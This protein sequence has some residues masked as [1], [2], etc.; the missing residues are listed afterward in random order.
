MQQKASRTGTLEVNGTQLY[1][2][3]WGAG[4][5][6]VLVHAGIADGRMWDEQMPVF[7]QHYRVIRFDQRGF[8]RSAPASGAFARHEDLRA[9]LAALEIER[10]HL[11]GCSMG[12]K[13]LIDVV[14]SYPAG[15]ASLT[16]VCTG[17]YAFQYDAPRPRQAD[18][19]NAAYEAGDIERASW[20]EVELWVDGPHRTPDQVPAA[21][22]EK[23]YQMNLQ[24]IR[25]ELSAEADEQILEPHAVDRLGEI[26]TPTLVIIGDL[27][28]PAALA[29][30]TFAA[31]SIPGAQKAVMPGTAH[32][33]SLERPD[34]FNRILADFLGR[35]RA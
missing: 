25:N 21:I 29:G 30:A 33:P 19:L 15:A 5:A 6:L 35:Q 9:L 14:L 8:G 32:L 24:A 2:E 16:L 28:N 20:L 11:V 13:M 12:G 4:P 34:E 23:V 3:E 17:P 18:A 27:D 26:Q 22:R 31:A 1:Y 7:A 10:A